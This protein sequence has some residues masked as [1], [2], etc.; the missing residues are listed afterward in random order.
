VG[1]GV[2]LAC[3]APLAA[4]DV[5]ASGAALAEAVVAVA[6][7]S[8]VA[9]LEEPALRPEHPSSANPRTAKSTSQAAGR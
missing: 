4:G 3:A 9:E 5:A 6:T 7:G 2:G 1:S 8:G